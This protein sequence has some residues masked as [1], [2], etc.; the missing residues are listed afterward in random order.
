MGRLLKNKKI[1][2]RKNV[3]PIQWHCSY[4]HA[5]SCRQIFKIHPHPQLLWGSQR[6]WL[7][8]IHHFSKK[9][10]SEGQLYSSVLS[11]ILRL[12]H[13]L[14]ENIAVQSSEFKQSLNLLDFEELTIGSEMN[15]SLIGQSPI[16]DKKIKTFFW[17]YLFLAI[18]R[19]EITTILTRST[20]EG[21]EWG[22]REWS[23]F[24]FWRSLITNLQC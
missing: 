4:H 8:Q 15:Y 9:C 13:S 1:K 17:G 2:N 5:N 24:P 21:G 18:F 14:R 22:R 16:F 6:L 7:W 19:N 11:L 10:V 12:N 20:S 23:R 3:T